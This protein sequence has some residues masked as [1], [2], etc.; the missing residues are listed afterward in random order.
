[1]PGSE[2]EAFI[3]E[4]EDLINEA[5]SPISGG[6]SKK[7]I[8]STAAYEILDDIKNSLPDEFQ[9]ARRII[10]ER[11]EILNSAETEAQHIVQDA[12]SHALMLA[13]EQEVVRMAHNEAEE[14]RR[15]AEKDARDIR[16]WAENSA[17]DTFGKLAT[18]MQQMI[19]R[20]NSMLEQVNY[21]RS[22]LS[23]SFENDGAM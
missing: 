14:V 8:D 23:G 13:S 10:H 9:K 18:E 6:G 4:L 2:I 5:K 12:E 21:C 1:M 11:D 15:E 19:D 16:Y 17:E 3:E 22:L 20:I 7:I